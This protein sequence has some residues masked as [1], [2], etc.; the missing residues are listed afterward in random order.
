MS[1]ARELADVVSTSPSTDINIDNGTLVVDISTDRVGIGTTTPGSTLDVQ[2]TLTVGVDDTGYDVKFFGATTGKYMLWDESADSL[3]VNGTVIDSD[4]AT[5]IDVSSTSDALRVTQT[6]TGNALVVEDSTNPDS[7]PFVINDLGNAVFGHT[8]TVEF[9]DSLA[10]TPSVQINRA[11]ATTFGISRFSD[12]SAANGIVLLKSRGTTIGDF[13]IV[14]DNDSIGSINFL[15]ADGN[16]GI[17]AAVIEGLIDGTPGTNDMPGRLVFS[18]TADGASSPTERMRIDS[19][20]TV[21]V[22][23]SVT[24][25]VSSGVNID[26]EKTTGAAIGFKQSGV[27]TCTIE[28]IQSQGGLRFYTGTSGSVSERLR[29]DSSG[30]V[31]VGYTSGYIGD[32]SSTT[33]IRLDSTGFLDLAAS[34][35]YVMRINRQSTDGDIISFRKDGATVGIIGT[36]SGAFYIGD[37]SQATLRFGAGSNAVYPADSSGTLTDNTM[38]LGGSS[39]A[40]KD[41]W[42]GGGIYLGGTGAANHLDDYEEGTWTPNPKGGTT[43][44]TYTVSSRSGKYRK[45]GNLVHCDATIYVTSFTGTGDFEVDGFPF[46]IGSGS[47]GGLVLTQWNACP[48]DTISADEQQVVGLTPANNDY[49]HFRACDRTAS[50][51]YTQLQCKSSPSTIV[52]LRLSLTY[53]TD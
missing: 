20:G 38:D 3:I 48:F 17:R 34:G 11:G 13:S 33:G 37:D 51:N 42:L 9:S 29:I 32:S 49:I 28:D 36:D 5:T 30:N 12:N 44:G 16:D 14:Q 52:Y 15:G 22:S 27:R 6:G 21:A 7:S 25:T 43:S 47:P 2:G 19:S 40:Y 41:L 8:G 18:T 50:A 4:G 1:N 26:L 53:H 39:L 46:N 35:S 45:V 10:I 31:L 23:G 24:S